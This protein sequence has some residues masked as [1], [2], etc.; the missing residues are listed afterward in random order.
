[1]GCALAVRGLSARRPCTVRG[2]SVVRPWAVCE[3]SMGCSWA[4]RT[5]YG[6]LTSFP[7]ADDEVSASCQR[8]SNGG[9][10][11]GHGLSVSFLSIG[12]PW[13]VLGLYVGCPR[14][15]RELSVACLWVV[16]GLSANCT[17]A[18]SHPRTPMDSPQQ[19]LDSPRNCHGLS[20]SGPRAASRSMSSGGP[21]AF[22]GLSVTYSRA[23]HCLS[24]TLSLGCPWARL[25]MGCP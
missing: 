24:R 6:L 21:R 9:C 8:I 25:I 18:L 17:C 10:R 12:C 5:T 14:T 16:D 4:V 1:M 13:A 3:L 19:T 15:T 7:R 11:D 2:L 23:T 20:A 22:R